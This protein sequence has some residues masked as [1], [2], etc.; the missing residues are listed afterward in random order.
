M[1]S[2]LAGITVIVTLVLDFVLIPLYGMNGAAVAST[3]A[4]TAYGVMGVVVLARLSDATIRELALPR[5]DDFSAYLRGVS[6]A[7]GV[8]S[9]ALKARGK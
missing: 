2:I 4:Y 1:S 8:V 6:A 9:R 7:V 3:V 5:R